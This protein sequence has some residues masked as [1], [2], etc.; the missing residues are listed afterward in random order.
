MFC[1]SRCWA[2]RC[3]SS[4]LI[5]SSSLIGSRSLT[6]KG[7]LRIARSA[8]A[9]PVVLP[10]EIGAELVEAGAADLAHHQVDLVDEDVDRLLDPGQPAGRGAVQ[11]RPAEE[12]EIGAAAQRDQ[13]VGAAPHAAVEQERQLVA[14]RGLDRRQDVER[15]RR[16]V[17]LAAAMVRYQDAVAAPLHPPPPVL[18]VHNA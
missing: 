14:D 2:M 3:R 18:R 11:G 4:M 5:A 7:A 15:A 10:Q 16:L 12:A 13:D 9:L 8:V 1:G 17:E 6:Q